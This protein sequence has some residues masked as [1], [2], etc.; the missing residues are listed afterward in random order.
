MLAADASGFSL[1]RISLTL[2]RRCSPQG[3]A[4]GVAK[5]ASRDRYSSVTHKQPNEMNK[6]RYIYR[7]ESRPGLIAICALIGENTTSYVGTSNLQEEIVMFI[8]I[9]MN[10][11]HEYLRAQIGFGGKQCSN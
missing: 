5:I 7:P 4:V 8:V 2:V 6:L 10:A 9:Y 11:L 3:P 1:N